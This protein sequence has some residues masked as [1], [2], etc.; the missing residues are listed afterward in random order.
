[1]KSL[2]GTVLLALVVGVP[3]G[4]ADTIIQGQSFQANDGIIWGRLAFPPLSVPSGTKLASQTKPPL[5]TTI[6][7]L[8]L[9]AGSTEC[10][11]FPG[12]PCSWQG[13]FNPGGYLLTDIDLG[14]NLGQGAIDL[15]FSR[16]Q[17]PV[18]VAALGFQIDAKDYGTFDYSRSF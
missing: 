12:L 17:G 5:I 16:G 8:S 2:I 3:L 14:T 6:D 15:G 4:Q 1:M 11:A 9:G 13:N 10:Q 7:F 18:G